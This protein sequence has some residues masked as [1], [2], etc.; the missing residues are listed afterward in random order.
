MFKVKWDGFFEVTNF[1][2]EYKNLKVYIIPYNGHIWGDEA[3]LDDDS[4][5]LIDITMSPHMPNFDQAPMFDG[6]V[7]HPLVDLG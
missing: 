7:I 4:N 6:R 3:Y 2:A 5:F 1:E